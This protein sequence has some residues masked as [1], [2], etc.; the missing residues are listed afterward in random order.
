MS[1]LLPWLFVPDEDRKQVVLKDSSILGAWQI[2]GVDIESGDDGALDAAA[3][4]MDG[5]LRRVADA[6]A[7]VWA[8]M[9]RLPVPHY[10]RGT[11]DNPVADYIDEVWGETFARQPIY[12]NKTFF[13][14]SMPTRGSSVSLG[15]MVGQG[16]SDG[17]KLPKAI[18]HALKARIRQSANIG[19]RDRAELSRMSGRFENTVAQVVNNS[20]HDM[21]VQRLDDA[22][23]LGYLKSTASVNPLAPVAY[24]EDEYLDT[25]LSDTFI[26]NTYKDYLVMEGQKRKYVGVYTLKSAPPGNMLQGL[27]PLM[28]LPMH[29]RIGVCW[30]SASR[31]QAERFLSGARSFDEMRGF[32]PRKLMKAVMAKDT[33]GGDDA[34]KTK[35]GAIAENYR[36][37][38]KRR[39]AFFGWCAATVTVIADSPEQL[40]DQMDEVAR[41]LEQTGMVFIRERDGSLSGFCAGIAGHVREIVRWH[42]VE[43][44]NMTDMTPLI[45]LDSGP[46]M[47]PF[48]SEG[49]PEPLPPN[50]IL[51]TRY[52]TVQYFNYHF[53]ELGHT[54]LI[55]PSRNGKTMFQMFLTTQFMKYPNARVFILDKDLSC[56]PTTLLLDGAH[57]DLDPTRGKGLKL[58][59]LV[60]AKD[61]PGRAWLVGW[62]DRVLE[63]RGKALTDAEIEEVYQALTRIASDPQARMSTLMTQLPDNLRVRLAPWCE[64]GAYGMY[65]D[66]TEDDFAF[67]R[68]TTTEVGSLINAGLHDVVRAYCDYAFYRIERFLQD[69][70]MSEVGPTMIYFEEAGFLLENPIFATRARDYLMTLAKK[71]AHLVM[72]AQS[73]EPFINQPDLGAAVRDNVATVIFLPN[74]KAGKAELARK[75][76]DAFGVSDTQ[77]NLIAGAI[78]KM[79]YCVFQLQAG[80]FRVCRAKFPKPIVACLRSDVKSQAV[81]D[82]YYDPE[83]AEWKEK[84]LA[85]VADA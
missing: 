8:T 44:G 2:E 41:R 13:A 18:F 71:R 72:T 82:R 36:S 46:P 9:E 16:V 75:Y 42:F 38:T 3:R 78:P 68:V 7:T 76:K 23:L 47:H 67:G 22:T 77:L 51:R 73:P 84:Y 80:M 52:N 15:E 53:G 40:E 1:E 14:A 27:N 21:R 35:L 64:G 45:S 85:A 49:M 62:I 26:D 30:R 50:A 37:M 25:Y 59:P 66:H 29:L 28:A 81:F 48:F 34:P 4:Q 31:A 63:S 6:G 54:L 58:N 43:A 60:V 32:T 10:V 70:P 17:Q 39:E 79:E 5:V 24:V 20:L 61:E 33:G 69:R 74:S 65:F 11:F 57:V 83:D 56:K 12:T 19:F 55:G